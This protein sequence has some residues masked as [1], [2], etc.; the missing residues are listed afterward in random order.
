M[1][2]AIY[3]RKSTKQHGRQSADRSLPPTDELRTAGNQ[4]ADDQKSVTRQIE[5]SRAFADAR[6][7]T[8]SDQHIYVDDGI[9]GAEFA[10]RPGLVRLMAAVARREFDFL[11]MME[12]SRLGREQIETPFLLKQAVTSGVRVFNYG[13]GREILLTTATDKIMLS[14]TAYADELERERARQRTHDAMISKARMGHVTGGRVFGYRNVEVFGNPDAF[15][16]RKRLYVVHEVNEAEAVVVRRIFHMRGEGY[17]LRAIAKR[18][19]EEGLPSPRPQLQR[20]SGWTATSLLSILD[21]DEYRGEVIYNKSKKRNDWGQKQQRPRPESEWIRVPAPDRRIVT[22]EQWHLAKKQGAQKRQ[23]FGRAS[24]TRSPGPRVGESKY[25]LPGLARCGDCNGTIHVRSRSH[26]KRRAHL[27]GCSTY[28]ERGTKVCGN[29]TVIAMADMNAAVINQLN[30]AVLN[31]AVVL[32]TVELV[33][34]RIEASQP[35]MGAV[36]TKIIAEAED[37]KARIGELV[38][39][40]A[41]GAQSKAV[42]QE[43]SALEEKQELLDDEIAACDARAVARLDGNFEAKV[44]TRI[45]DWRGTLG[46]N[47]AATRLLLKKLLVGPIVMTAM[48]DRRGYQFEG[49]VRLD[50]LTGIGGALLMASPTGFEPVF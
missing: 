46:G 35:S 19:N 45:R 30:S 12:G 14:I 39:F 28:H 40:I 25:L 41:T 13:D 33:R 23:V 31:E 37:I 36:R 50:E 18:L 47:V 7:W 26:G 1:K 11:I 48:A 4:T 8:V 34:E 2:A 27:Y 20:P 21:R 32:R 5:R 38:Q 43:L 22:D 17:G 44:V 24:E 16:E 15:G 29:G 42:A 3:A 49:K 6:G 10:A 9:S